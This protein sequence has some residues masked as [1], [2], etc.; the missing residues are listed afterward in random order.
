MP[1]AGT[2]DCPRIKQHR[3]DL[4]HVDD[5]REDHHG[6]LRRSLP[7]APPTPFATLTKPRRGKPTRQ[8]LAVRCV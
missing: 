7:L 1:D 4:A 2:R 8:T 5:A 3:P 6:L